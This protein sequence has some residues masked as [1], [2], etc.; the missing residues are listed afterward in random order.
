MVLVGQT[1]EYSLYLSFRLWFLIA[2]VG[3]FYD[4]DDDVGL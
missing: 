1:T 4:I 3:G 2:A